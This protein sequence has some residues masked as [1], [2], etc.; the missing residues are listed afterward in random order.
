MKTKFLLPLVSCMA[1]SCAHIY[2]KSDTYDTTSSVEI[3]GAKVKSGVK[4]MGGKQ[5]LSVSAMI[6]MAGSAKLEG[7]FIWRIEAEGDS[8]VHDYIVVHRVKVETQKTNR[9]EW[10]PKKYLGFRADFKDYKKEQGKSFAV[11]Q[12]PGELKVDPKKDGDITI[13]A[14]VSVKSKTRNVRKLV[15]FKLGQKTKQKDLEFIFFPTEI[16]NSFG[17]SDPREWKF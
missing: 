4:P 9:K 5:G 7:P 2:T 12:F 16:V 15:R 13:T 10:F 11:Y 14:D 8:G 1:M 3:N 6:Y 17:Q